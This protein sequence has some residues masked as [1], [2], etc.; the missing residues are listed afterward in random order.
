MTSHT[1]VGLEFRAFMSPNPHATDPSRANGPSPQFL[2]RDPVVGGR[3][4]R[5][6]RIN[7]LTGCTL[8]VGEEWRFR[9]TRISPAGARTPKTRDDR[10]KVYV[11]LDVLERVELRSELAFDREK[12]VVRWRLVSGSRQLG[13]P[14]AP[15]TAKPVTYRIDDD[16]V[17]K[18]EEISV[19]GKFVLMLTSRVQTVDALVQSEMK[20]IGQ[21]AN[22]RRI[23]RWVANLPPIPDHTRD[24]LKANTYIPEVARMVA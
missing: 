18:G 3:S 21:S 5:I 11:Y 10:T 17:I 13:F 20:L 1:F 12:G 4:M 7:D 8:E 14:E 9:V 19:D 22:H 2:D 6:F 15:A 24:F 23:R 16:Y